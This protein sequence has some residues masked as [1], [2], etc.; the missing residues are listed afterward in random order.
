MLSAASIKRSLGLLSCASKAAPP[1]PD[2]PRSPVPANVEIGGWLREVA[3]IRVHAETKARPIDRLAEETPLFLP[4]AALWRPDDA[5][6]S[7]ST[8]VAPT[9][10]P[11]SEIPSIAIEQHNLALYDAIGRAA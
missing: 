8:S 4:R 7:A 6:P 11:M 9:A 5:P 3:N 2:E 1:S 10:A